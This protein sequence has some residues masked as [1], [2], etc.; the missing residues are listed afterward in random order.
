LRCKPH[1]RRKKCGKGKN[2]MHSFEP[3][4]RLAAHV[5]LRRS[6]WSQYR[7]SI[8]SGDAVEP[9]LLGALMLD[10]AAVEADRAAVAADRAI[11]TDLNEERA[12]LTTINGA[13]GEAFAH[14]KAVE[15]EIGRLIER[16]PLSPKVDAAKE[17]SALATRRYERLARLATAQ[18]HQ[19]ATTGQQIALYRDRNPRLFQP[20]D[21]WIDSFRNSAGSDPDADVPGAIGTTV[22]IRRPFTQFAPREVK[23]EP[24]A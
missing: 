7:R 13:V 15:A 6:Q 17:R 18:Q 9:E 24:I 14:V 1:T 21:D 12:K 8:E 16:D 11:Q 3:A 2:L 20:L 5:T 23:P 10:G 19:V 22:E 4:M